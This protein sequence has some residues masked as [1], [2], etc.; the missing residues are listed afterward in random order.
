MR[1]YSLKEYKMATIASPH[2]HQLSRPELPPETAL[3]QAWYGW[4]AMVVVAALFFLYVSGQLMG[5]EGRGSGGDAWFIA[6][7]A[8][9]VIAAPLAFF[10]RSRYFRKYWT[11]EGVP[12]RA[13]LTG[14]LIT[15]SILTVGV[16]LSLLGCLI[17]HALLP[18]LFPG[19]VA[20]VMLLIMFPNGGAMSTQGRGATDDHGTYEEPR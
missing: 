19:G 3:R 9:I 6:S 2:G 14:Q 16:L 20:M 11:G 7:A 5:A 13:Y 4:V 12:P 8:Y 10:V 1:D 18:G 15:W 17:S